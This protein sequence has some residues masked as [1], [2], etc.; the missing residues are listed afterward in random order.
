MSRVRKGK[1]TQTK[2][3]F[4]DSVSRPA[5]LQYDWNSYKN[6]YAHSKILKNHY[7]KRI[8]VESVSNR[9]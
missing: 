3:N 7:E 1:F 5:W 2:I 4:I 8:K 6:L 9:G